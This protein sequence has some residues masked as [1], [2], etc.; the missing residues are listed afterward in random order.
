MALKNERKKILIV[1]DD[2]GMRQSIRRLLTIDGKYEIQEAIDGYDAEKKLKK[3]TPHLIIIDVK[4]PGKDGYATCMHI[5]DSLGLKD[6]KIVGISGISGGIG[7]AFMEVLGANFYFEKP[8]DTIKFKERI[9]KLLE[10]DSKQE[11]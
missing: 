11:E 4:M 8:F 1:D 10:E 6:V 5:R 2:E 7:A 3:F 9:A